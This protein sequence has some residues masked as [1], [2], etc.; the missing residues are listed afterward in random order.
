MLD[1][2]DTV[3]L[4]TLKTGTQQKLL[5]QE[6]ENIF[7]QIHTSAQYMDFVATFNISLDLSIIYLFCSF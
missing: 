3:D 5:P 4:T 7:E 6:E 1:S 2:A